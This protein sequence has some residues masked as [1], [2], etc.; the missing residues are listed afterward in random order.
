MRVLPDINFA[1]SEWTFHIINRVPDW[2]SART[3]DTCANLLYLSDNAVPATLPLIR[4]PSC[5]SRMPT[6]A[7]PRATRVSV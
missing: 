7:H 3:L 5:T 1:R 6:A 2:R 4:Q